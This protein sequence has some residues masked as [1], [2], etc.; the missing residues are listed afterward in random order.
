MIS[1]HDKNCVVVGRMSAALSDM[2][3][4]EGATLFRPTETATFFGSGS[5][6]LGSYMFQVAATLHW[7]RPPLPLAPAPEL[8]I[9]APC[10]HLILR[11]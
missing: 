1:K 11:K 6:G 2:E 9:Q 7:L 8:Q 4:S 3:V 5:S 10:S